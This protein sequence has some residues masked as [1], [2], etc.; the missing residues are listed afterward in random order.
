M[1]RSN[2]QQKW[3]Y[4]AWPWKVPTWFSYAGVNVVLSGVFSVGFLK[5]PAVSAITHH[6]S[7]C[8]LC[9]RILCQ[10]PAHLTDQPGK[11]A[12]QPYSPVTAITSHRDTQRGGPYTLTWT[13]LSMPNCNGTT[14][15]NR[16]KT[17][18]HIHTDRQTDRQTYIHTYIHAHTYTYI[19]TY[20]YTYTYSHTYR[21]TSIHTYIHTCIHTYRHRHT[22]I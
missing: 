10:H 4:I 13:K 1:L 19:H 5:C 18:T 21:Q 17:H 6:L 11:G 8:Y 9:S 20:I 12:R 22:N 14:T 16:T 3:G 15:Y 2:S 7:W